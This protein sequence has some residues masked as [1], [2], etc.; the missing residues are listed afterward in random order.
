MN[1]PNVGCKNY[2]EDE[3]MSESDD[4]SVLLHPLKK[5]STAQIEELLSETISAALGKKMEV[6]IKKIDYGALRN[7]TEI[8]LSVSESTDDFLNCAKAP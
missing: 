3:I 8:S 4:F 1:R 5:L 7:G 2:W 6:G